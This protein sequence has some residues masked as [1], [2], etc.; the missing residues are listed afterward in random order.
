MQLYLVSIFSQ[1]L[2]NL[3]LRQKRFIVKEVAYMATV[4]VLNKDGKPLMPTT[5]C[6]HIRH[7]LKEKKAR[8]V[9]TNPF[10]IKLVYETDDVV[11]PLYLG[12]DPG[13]TNIG[14][15]V[16]KVDGTAVFTA[17]LETRN[18]EIPKLMAKRK[19]HRQ[20][21]RHY[22]RCKRQ[23][24]AAAHGTLSKKCKKQDTAQGGNISKRAQTI[25]VFERNLPGCENSVLCIGIKN[26]E[27]RFNNRVRPARWLTP[28]ANQL[29]LTHVNFVK[30]ICK[31]LPISDVV[32]EINKFAFMALD[33]P[34]IQK[35]Q[36]Q[37]GPLYQKGS[38]ENA[39]SEQQ[40]HHCLFCEK[41][42]EHYHHVILR[43]ENGSDTIANI[44]GLC[45]EHHDL[46][47]KDD[48]L[49]E[50]L[51][52]KKQGLNKKY[53]ALSVLNQI[54]P[55]LTYELGSRFQGHF[56]VTTGKSTY[57]YRAAHSVSKDHWL[58][59]YC[60]ACSV[61]PDGCFDNTINSRVPYELKQFRRHD[62]QVCQQQ[63][64]KR[65]YYLDKKL[66]ATNRHKAIK[67]E[68]DSLEEYRN[69]GGTTDK[70]VVKEHKPTNKR[71]NRILPGALMAAN[72]KLNVMVAS[73]G[74]HN[75]IPD[76]YVFDNNSKAKPSKCTLINKNKGIVF[77]LNSVS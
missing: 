48:K 19:E 2:H 21:R 18:K 22:R 76:N 64:V 47:H 50:E 31:F 38:L 9:R 62:R 11:Q 8:V 30:K 71:L 32:L 46:I 59:A 26:K 60:I 41:T 58:D 4:Y 25:G 52:K 77:V 13:R 54:I 5:R 57:D 75:G 72:G 66:V 63:N 16:V 49:K 15:A 33:N 12:I 6:G 45:A 51:A 27:A 23:R 37:Q 17:H 34:N 44:V 28:T 67:Q 70:L 35:W 43:S 3:L 74:L 10:T 68:T 61:L 65:K 39:V 7:L 73:R 56:Y 20:G 36:Y 69:N 55:A 1:G 14:V 42:I 29:L 24:R 40:D 53:G